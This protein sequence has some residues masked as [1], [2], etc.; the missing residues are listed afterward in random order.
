MSNLSGHFLLGAAAGIYW[1]S[2]ELAVPLNC[3][4]I[5]KPS[6]GYFLAKSTDAIVVIIGVFIG[7]AW[8]YYKMPRIIYFMDFIC[9]LYIFFILMSRLEMNRISGRS[10]ISDTINYKKKIHAINIIWNW[11]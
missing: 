7:T 10:Q 1:P 11:Q 5:I 4:N 6:E 3:N 2:A 8:T 9:I